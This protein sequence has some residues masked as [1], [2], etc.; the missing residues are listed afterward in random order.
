M[1]FD[2]KLCVML[3]LT[4]KKNGVGGAIS[5]EYVKH[6]NTSG[7]GL[8]FSF[9]TILGRR[10][11]AV[12]GGILLCYSAKSPC[13]LPSCWAGLGGVSFSLSPWRSLRLSSQSN[14]LFEPCEGKLRSLVCD[15]PLRGG[16]SLPEVLGFSG[17]HL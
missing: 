7:T 17:S 13:A 10:K 14:L 2:D 5:S 6:L 12:W 8:F 11:K 3:R 15:T 16:K 4:K 1:G 9:F